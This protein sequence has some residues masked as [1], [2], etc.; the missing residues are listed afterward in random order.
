[1]YYEKTSIQILA[2]INQAECSLKGDKKNSLL[3]KLKILL[4]IYFCYKRDSLVELHQ[5][6]NNLNN[7]NISEDHLKIILYGLQYRGLIKLKLLNPKI[8]NR[9]LLISVMA[10]GTFRIRNRKYFTTKEGEI[11]LAKRDKKN[12]INPILNIDIL[13]VNY[14]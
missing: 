2:I 1:M 3:D 13:S 11:Y 14:N 9:K 5:K 6:F 10:K 4:K 12:K 7:N 8:S